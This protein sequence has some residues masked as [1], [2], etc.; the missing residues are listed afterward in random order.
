MKQILLKRFPADLH[1]RL[2]VYAVVNDT[3]MKQV[4]IEAVTKYLDEQEGGD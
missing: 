1:K 3:N 2:K 4:I